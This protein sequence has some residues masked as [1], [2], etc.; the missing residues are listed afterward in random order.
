MQTGVVFGKNTVKG[1][2]KY[3]DNGSALTDYWGAGWFLAFT[4]NDLA[5][6][7]SEFDSVKVGLR[8][9]MGSGLQEIIT[10]VDKNGTA[11]IDNPREQVFVV[12][13]TKGTKTQEQVWSLAGLTKLA[14]EAEG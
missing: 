7:W 8:P 6:D 2:L 1:D 3:V 14:P 11:K 12:Q 5:N 13:K 10:D 9:S 4:M